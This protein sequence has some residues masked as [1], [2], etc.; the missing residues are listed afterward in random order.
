MAVSSGET[1]DCHLSSLFTYK[2]LIY[3]N[4]GDRVKFVFICWFTG[5]NC[6][7]VKGFS[8]IDSDGKTLQQ[9]M[10]L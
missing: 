10:P 8:P 9:Q 3:N 7:P 4:L 5:K 1:A 6:A 2:I